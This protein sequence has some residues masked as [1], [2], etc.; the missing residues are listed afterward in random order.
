MTKKALKLSFEAHQNQVDKSGM[1]YVFHPFHLAEQ[2]E[3]ENTTIVALLH[4]VVED[5]DIGFD[6]LYK[7]GF[8]QTVIEALKLLTHD[9]NEPYNG[10]FIEVTHEVYTVLIKSDRKI[11][12]FENDLKEEKIILD[13]KGTVVEI[14]P[15]REDSLDRLQ[16]DNERQFADN[17]DSVEEIALRNLRYEQLHNAIVLKKLIT[18][19]RR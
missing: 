12:Y 8:S 7:M 6:E 1:P 15:S 5:T 18:A 16:D 14:I 4:D 19:F 10:Q 3:D 13:K 9:N 17:S 2:M 11:K